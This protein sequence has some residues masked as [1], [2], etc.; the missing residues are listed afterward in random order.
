MFCVQVCECI[1]IHAFIS[2]CVC[3]CVCVH[4]CMC[5]DM[6]IKIMKIKQNENY[7]V[8]I[9]YTLGLSLIPSI[10]T[11]CNLVPFALKVPFFLSV[12]PIFLLVTQVSVETRDDDVSFRMNIHM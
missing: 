11:Q 6:Y 4:A 8:F 10:Y 3:V 5:M 7:L 12:T 9:Q 2:V 1:C